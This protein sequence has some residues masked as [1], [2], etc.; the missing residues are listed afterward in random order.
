MPDFDLRAGDVQVSKKIQYRMRSFGKIPNY[1]KKAP[2]DNDVYMPGGVYVRNISLIYRNE[3]LIS[4]QYDWRYHWVG[5][6][7]IIEQDRDLKYSIIG[8]R[9]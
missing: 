4:A 1:H 7:E 3:Q 9:Y 8:R 5:I 2:W 6:T